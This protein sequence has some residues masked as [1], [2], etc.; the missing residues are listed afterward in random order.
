MK[1]D[2]FG[3]RMKLYEGIESNRMLIPLLPVCVRLDGN[4][5][6]SFTRGFD[7][8]YDKTLRDMMVDT[9]RY[10]VDISG[11]C[12]GY[13]QSDEISLVIYSDSMKSQIYFNGRIMKLVSILAAK[14]TAKFLQ[15]V[16]EKCPHK[17]DELP[18]FDCRVWNVPT[19]IEAANSFLWRE[20]DATKNSISMAAGSCYSHN[21]LNGKSGSEKQEMLW[22]KGIN[23]NDYPE[24]FKRG[25]FIRRVKRLSRFSPE[26]IEVLP[27]KHEARFNSNLLIERT[28]IERVDMPPFRKV[29]NRVDVVFNGANPI[30][31]TEE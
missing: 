25:V 8:P 5:F 4:C 11:A 14:A 7:R 24:Y 10:L 27:E 15:L 29:T 12:M 3:N 13:T 6:H 2:D 18:V 22:E 30:V 9:T 16:V 21:E 19:L 28:V 31:K 26:E 20:M 23:W 17:F 1:N